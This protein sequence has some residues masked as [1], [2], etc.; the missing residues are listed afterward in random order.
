MPLQ[1]KS[2]YCSCHMVKSVNKICNI[3]NAYFF[4]TELMSALRSTYNVIMQYATMHTE[5][6]I[7]AK[8]FIWTS[9]IFNKQYGIFSMKTLMKYN[10]RFDIFLLPFNRFN[11]KPF[12]VGK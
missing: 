6:T 8:L 11:D 5:C 2:V 10:L 9:K 3:L 4:S 7:S 12:R 1:Y